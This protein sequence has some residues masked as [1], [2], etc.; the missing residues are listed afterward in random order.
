MIEAPIRSDPLPAEPVCHAGVTLSLAPAR[1]RY[2]VRT[3]VPRDLPVK[4]TTTAPFGSGTALCLGPDEWL[5]MLLDGTP[6]PAIPGAHSVT[7]VSHRSIGIKI[8]GPKAEALLLTGC[9]LDLGRDF[10]AGKATRTLYDGVEIILW[11]IGVESFHIDV[12]RSFAPYLWAALE[13]AASDF[14]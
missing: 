4:V 3:R 5:L 2:S 1:V 6:A 11:R 7:D 14:R 8:E 10:P 9:A 13:L 12:W